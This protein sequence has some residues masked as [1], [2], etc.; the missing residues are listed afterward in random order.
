MSRGQPPNVAIDG[1]LEV[2]GMAD[3]E[4]IGDPHI[5]ETTGNRRPRGN[6]IQRIA[7][8]KGSSRLGMEK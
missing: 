2:K 7:D 4:E 1:P 5:V 3:A 8:D 6:P